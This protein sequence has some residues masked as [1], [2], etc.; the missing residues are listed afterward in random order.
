MKN[1][2]VILGT[3]V[4]AVAFLVFGLLEILENPVIM[5]LMIL[6]YLAILIKIILAVSKSEPSDKKTTPERGS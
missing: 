4:F 2:S 3:A 1:R 6:G 5:G